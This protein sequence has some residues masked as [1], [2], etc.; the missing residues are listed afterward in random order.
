MRPVLLMAVCAACGQHGGDDTDELLDAPV[1]MSSVG[2]FESAT[3]IGKTTGSVTVAIPPTK[4]GDKL[5]VILKGTGS[6]PSG[7]VTAGRTSLALAIGAMIPEACEGWAWAWLS[8]ALPEGIDSIGINVPPQASVAGYAL[9]F[10]GLSPTV[11]HPQAWDFG[12][13][14]GSTS[15]AIGPSLLSRSRNVLVSAVGTCGSVG[16]LV[17]TSPFIELPS[18]DGVTVAYYIPTEPGTYGAEWNFIDADWVVASLV[19]R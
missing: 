3:V 16:D 5:V 4:S 6:G 1:P 11:Y 7:P 17:P 10:S 13:N 19:L 18:V 2:A 12:F 9:V 15:N 14:R 8:S